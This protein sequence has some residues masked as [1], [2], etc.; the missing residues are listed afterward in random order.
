MKQVRLLLLF[1][2]FTSC[3]T[4][5]A[6]KNA[7][8]FTRKGIKFYLSAHEDN[9]IRI[10]A[11]LSN[12]KRYADQFKL[13]LPQDGV[14]VKDKNGNFVYNNYT[15]TPTKDGYILSVE[16]VERYRSSFEIFN[17]EELEEIRTYNSVES[18][19]GMGQVSKKTDLKGSRFAISH[20]PVYGDQTYMYIPFYI[21]DSLD[22]VYYNAQGFDNLRFPAD[23]A[24]ELIYT[25]TTGKIDTYYRLGSSYKDA[26]SSFYKSTDS[27]SLLPEWAFGFIQS[28][29]GYKNQEEVVNIV[30]RFKKENIKISGLVLDLYWFRKM[31]DLDWDREKF[32]DPE[33]MT[34]YLNDNGIKLITITEPFFTND[35]LRYKEFE[36]KGFF[37][38]D[39]NNKTVTWSDWWCFGSPYGAVVNPIADGVE[40]R[41]GEIYSD[42]I[43]SGIDGFWTDL[44]EPERVPGNAF[45]SGISER[46]FHNYYNREWSRIIHDGVKNHYPDKRLFILSRSGYTGSGRYN[47]SIWTG[48]V[49]ANF[50]ALKQQIPLGLN[51]GLSGFSYWGTDVGG[52]VPEFSPPELMVR[53]YQFGI[54]N[55]VFRA[56]GT[57]D[58]EPWSAGAENTKIIKKYIDYRYKLMPYTYSLSAYTYRD[59]LPIMRPMFM[60]FENIPAAFNDKQFMYGDYILTAPVT[61]EMAFNTTIDVYLPEGKWYE[62]ETM[63]EYNGG[64]IIKEKVSLDKI[65]IFLRE[66]SIIPV[67]YKN[68]KNP[69]IIIPSDNSVS[70]F[71][72]YK[73][74]GLTENYKK[75]DF[76]ETKYSLNNSVL[77]YSSTEKVNEITVL[78]PSSIEVKGTDWKRDGVYNVKSF[79]TGDFSA[80]ITLF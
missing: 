80:D 65:P 14:F 7:A 50:N 69:L 28:K 51:A 76:T 79:K 36:E 19:H 73:D 56:H 2:V 27:V 4:L 72:V 37:A 55:P 77:S 43:K 30:E 54:F 45:F 48:D 41:F 22:S 17:K 49:G 75:G 23:S 11:F 52:F 24:D 66:G 20:T 31:G 57:G 29:Y 6:P 60:E 70:E 12:H 64:G 18:F 39:S 40:K 71:I 35:S 32:P 34:K 58:R 62:F 21:T 9:Y 26:V 10:N 5:N 8:F 42:M 13:E 15:V 47:V 67:D 63:N 44:G 68:Y 38:V 16:G 3:T 74:D 61:G 78:I 59:G 46:F 25:T 53:W 33:G 1:V